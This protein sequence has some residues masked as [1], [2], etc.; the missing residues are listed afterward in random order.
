MGSGSYA[1]AGSPIMRD[2]VVRITNSMTDSDSG[3]TSELFKVALA[4]SMILS[5]DMAHAVHPNYASKHEMNHSPKMNEG[6]AI[7][8]I[9]TSM[10]RFSPLSSSSLN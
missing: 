6:D 2:A 7:N 3:E 4:K 5:V 9:N 8:I 10:T 1:G